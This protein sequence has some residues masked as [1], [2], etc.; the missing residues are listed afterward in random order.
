ME[1]NNFIQYISLEKQYSKHTVK[2]YQND[3]SAFLYYIHDAFEISKS[4]EVTRDMVRSWIVQLIEED[5]SNITINRKLSTLKS[6]FNYLIKT[7]VVTM[8]PVKNITALKIPSYLPHFITKEKMALYYSS[9]KEIQDYVSLRNFLI[10]DILYTT[11]IREDELINLKEE[12]INFQQNTFKVTG[13]RNK[14]R[15]IPFSENEKNYIIRYRYLKIE[16]FTEENP[17]LI[18]TNKGLKAYPK[19]IYRIVSDELSSVTQSKKSPHVLRHTFAT[20]MLNEGA[21]LN[22][23]KEILGHANLSATQVYTHNTIEQLKSIYNHAH[24][25]AQLK[26]EV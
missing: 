22:T 7:G 9:K 16:R 15:I 17:Y 20:H 24:P 5:K 6:Y 2:A 14:Q 18:V 19:F 26:K 10:V 23:I 12:D 25:R 13:K 1:I 21:D 8:N 11:G 3:L 4:T